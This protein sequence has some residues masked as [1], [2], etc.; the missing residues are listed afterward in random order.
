[1][2]YLNKRVLNKMNNIV[3]LGSGIAGISASYHLNKKGFS[4]IIFEQDSDWGGL[5]SYFTIDG[6]RFD[7]FVHLSFANDDYIKNIF[8][9]STLLK[10]YSPD[11]YSY[12]KDTWLKHPSQNNLEPLGTEEKIKIITDFIKKP[13]CINGSIE[14]YEQWLRCQYGNYFAENFPFVY[15]RKYWGIEPKEMETKWLGQR[16]YVPTF[17]ELLKGAF[18]KQDRN[19][20]YVPTMSYPQKGGFRSI[21]DSTRKNLEIELNKK[22]I[23]INTKD[24]VI[25]FSD[26]S[27]VRYTE[28]I[29]SIPLPELV[30]ALESVPED[31]LCASKKLRHTSGYQVSLGFNKPDIAK[32]LWFYIYDE[33]ILPA[34][35]YSPNLKSLD[36]VP[37]GCSSLQAEIFFECN[38]VRIDSEFVLNKTISNLIQMKL[39]KEEDI[40]IKDVRFEKYANIIFDQGIYKNRELVLNYLKTQGIQAIGR[41]GKWDYLWSHQAYA[42]GMNVSNKKG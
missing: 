14:N 35:V 15:T 20:Y 12:Y 36:N 17:Q 13:E 26:G 9:N 7:R 16:M 5:C 39:F 29:S 34:R 8:A 10:E 33:N 1:M 27:H 32:C 19:F 31:I 37:K 21:L 25:L 28:L 3:V 11:P 23:S 4:S 30:K 40:I 38:S 24:K 22:A 2:S 6:F 41:F 18:E 42:D